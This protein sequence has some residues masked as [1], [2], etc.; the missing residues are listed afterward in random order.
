MQ[1]SFFHKIAAC[2]FDR[3]PAGALAA[4]IQSTPLAPQAPAFI[5]DPPALVVQVYHHAGQRFERL[6]HEQQEEAQARLFKRLKAR[7]QALGIQWGEDE[8]DMDA[9][10]EG[11]ADWSEDKQAAHWERHE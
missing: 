11:F 7:Q 3:E 1:V 6:T 2:L 10:P 9:L 5:P 8:I 4:S